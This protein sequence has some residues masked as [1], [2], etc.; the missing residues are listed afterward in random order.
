[1]KEYISRAYK[2]GRAYLYI[3]LIVE[4]CLSVLQSYLRS[5]PQLLLLT[6]IVVG[7]EQTHQQYFVNGFKTT[8]RKDVFDYWPY[9]YP[10]LYSLWP[11]LHALVE[12]SHLLWVLCLSFHSKKEFTEEANRN[13]SRGKETFASE[14]V[15]IR[16][17]LIV[18][19][20][21]HYQK[22]RSGFHCRL[23]LSTGATKAA[24]SKELV[25]MALYLADRDLD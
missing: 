9:P 17:I 1:M 15:Y 2:E 12:S 20:G 24:T 8:R 22:Q 10:S 21:L 4:I 25:G 19:Y 14:S 7:P 18:K 13:S 11:V 23:S 5:I 3:S 16:R 6:M